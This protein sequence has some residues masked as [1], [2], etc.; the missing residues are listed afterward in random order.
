MLTMY[1]AKSKTIV[2]SAI[3]VYDNNSIQICVNGI[4]YNPDDITKN[5]CIKFGLIDRHGDY[6]GVWGLVSKVDYDKYNSNSNDYI[7]V[8][9]A[10]NTLAGLKWGTVFP[11][12]LIG[13]KIPQFDMNLVYDNQ[14]MYKATLQII[15]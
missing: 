7:T 10:N 3:F 13:T 14:I 8:V 1:E 4:P 2:S 11:L 6:E 5:Y 9:L 12:K 15:K